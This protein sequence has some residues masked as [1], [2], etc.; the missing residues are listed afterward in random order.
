M[1]ALAALSRRLRNRCLR[2]RSA[3]DRTR[4][5]QGG[6]VQGDTL[7]SISGFAY[8]LRVGYR[9]PGFDRLL[10]EPGS[11]PAH[12]HVRHERVQLGATRPGRDV[13]V[14]VREYGLLRVS[15]RVVP[16]A[17]HARHGLVDDGDASAAATAATSATPAATTTARRH[18]LRPARLPPSPCPGVRVRIARA[19]GRRWLVARARVTRAAP[20]RLQLLRRNRTIAS[21][22]K[23]FRAGR[24]ELRLRSGARFLAGTYLARLTI[25]GA[26]RPYTTRISIG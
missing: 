15:L 6:C 3:S 21:T 1:K 16:H 22:R 26:A 7:V 19:G 24:N 13:P 20:A 9:Q 11:L 17:Q 25:G 5:H 23:R 12:G 14:H 2:P 10:D 18:R 4:W 8:S